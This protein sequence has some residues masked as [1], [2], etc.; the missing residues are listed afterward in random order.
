MPPD[1]AA[2][3]QAV[4]YEGSIAFEIREHSVDRVVAEMPVVAGIRNPFGTVHAG[5]LLWFA[6]V[7]A[8]VLAL[9]NTT[10]SPDGKGFPLALNLSAQLIGNV[11]E[12]MVTAQALFVRKGRRVSVIRT[13]VHDSSE[14]LLVDVTT[15]HMP[16]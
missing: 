1:V 14:R 6:D 8:T 15:T 11:R 16:A 7:T 5:A 3:A 4:Q 12:G 13:T 10:V 9:Q 2:L